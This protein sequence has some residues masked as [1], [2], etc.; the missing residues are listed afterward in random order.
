MYAPLVM[1]TLIDLNVILIE[2]EEV[3]VL[4][5]DV[6]VVEYEPVVS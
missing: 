5:H 3:V 2:G 6:K 4:I 1:L